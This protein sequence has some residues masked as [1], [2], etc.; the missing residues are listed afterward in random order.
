MNSKQFTNYKQLPWIN[1]YDFKCECIFS[2]PHAINLI[3]NK[4][5]NMTDQEWSKLSANPSIFYPQV[6]CVI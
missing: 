5:Q 1:I 2:N 3:E 4:T 6:Y